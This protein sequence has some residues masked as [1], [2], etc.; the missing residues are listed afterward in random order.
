[1]WNVLAL[2]VLVVAFLAKIIIG[3]SPSEI[4]VNH[5]DIL[6]WYGIQVTIA[7]FFAVFDKPFILYSHIIQHL[8]FRHIKGIYLKYCNKPEEV[9]IMTEKLISHGYNA[10]VQTLQA[11]HTQEA[12]LFEIVD[13]IKSVDPNVRNFLEM[14]NT[15]MNFIT[16]YHSVYY[17]LLSFILVST[18]PLKYLE[19]YIKTLSLPYAISI[20]IALIIT[21]RM[22]ALFR[23][24][25]IINMR[26]FWYK[27]C[28]PLVIFLV[29][30]M[31]LYVVPRSLFILFPLFCCIVTP[32]C[33]VYTINSK[34]VRIIKAIP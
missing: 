34:L 17:L 2:L 8:T 15:M 7:L 11:L 27:H 19:T 31:L 5:S 10:E 14:Q 25:S 12:K 21:L 33:M 23:N 18:L 24:E 4:F 22:I 3:T 32:L 26:D 30:I 16:K 1:M 6:S 28:I 20:V 13:A 9:K 29:N